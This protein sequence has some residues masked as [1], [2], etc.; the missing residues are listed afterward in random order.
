MVE[1]LYTSGEYLN[2]QPNWHVGESPWKAREILRM[3]QRNNIVAHTICEIGCGAGEVLRQLQTK[4]PNDCTF[5]GYEISPQAFELCQTRANERLLFKLLDIREE[6]HVFFD[7][8]LVLDVLEHLEDYFSFLKMVKSKS[9]FKIFQ[10]PMDLSVRSVLYGYLIEYRDLY[11]HL[12]YFTKETALRTLEDAGYTILDYFYTHE[13]VVPIGIQPNETTGD[14]FTRV[15]RLVGKTK[16]EILKYSNRL[17]FCIHPD[18]AVRVTGR[19]R[20]MILAQ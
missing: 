3:M 18:L 10:I 15:K 7:L 6:E 4:L 12:H 1:D 13:S 5:W 20:L 9:T 19:W 16:N 14:P 2:K 8:I 11:G 17:F